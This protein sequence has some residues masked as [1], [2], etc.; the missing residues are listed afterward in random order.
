MNT[1]QS[2]SFFPFIL[3]IAALAIAHALPSKANPAAGL[4]CAA[5]Y[6]LLA[7]WGG[8]RCFMAR[9]APS[10]A[11][12]L[13][14]VAWLAWCFIALTFL[15]VP[16]AGDETITRLFIGFVAFLAAAFWMRI[17]EDESD[18]HSEKLLLLFIIGMAGIFILMA[19]HAIWQRYVGYAK[20]LRLMQ[21]TP[22]AMSTDPIMRDAI[23]WALRMKAPGSTFGDPNT[24]AALLALGVGLLGGWAAWVMQSQT[25][26]TL[27]FAFIIPAAL[28]CFFA[29]ILTQS[30]GGVLTLLLALA[31]TAILVWST[32]GQSEQSHRYQRLAA[33]VA[34]CVMILL[35]AGISFAL[36]SS[37]LG[38]EWRLR[39]LSWSTMQQRVFY[40]T[41]ALRMWREHPLLGHGTGAFSLL[42][43]KYRIPGSGEAA[44]PHNFIAR[45]LAEQGLIGLAFFMLFAIGSVALLLRKKTQSTG[46]QL[47]DRTAGLAI[48]LILF[49]SLMQHAFSTREVYVNFCIFAGVLAGGSRAALHPRLSRSLNVLGLLAL[50]AGAWPSFI[51]PEWIRLYLRRSHDAGDVAADLRA[52]GNTLQSAEWAQR[53]LDEANRA[54]RLR[55]N[56]PWTLEYKAQLLFYTPELRNPAEALALQESAIALNPYSATFHDDRA[57]M[58]FAIGQT[59]DAFREWSAAI[60][61]HPLNEVLYAH[62]AQ[63][64]LS[65]DRPDLA[66]ED[67]YQAWKLTKRSNDRYWQTYSD[68]ARAAGRRAKIDPG[69]QPLAGA[70]Q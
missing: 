27:H 49:N 68:I 13:F 44:D 14:A 31:G 9:I 17:A 53:L 3:L 32:L 20:S 21:E 58:L 33:W 18:E 8:G 41:S 56:D 65:L 29:I 12:I 70:A 40:I 22:G 1:R 62:R 38:R 61:I 23:M 60:G 2:S 5:T 47:L 19:V 67:A 37:S 30:R 42:Y 54:L 57:R 55:H 52:Q 7:I 39:L 36:T 45:I 35:V 50:C 34:L 6:A 11:V 4:A 46:L 16:G 48:V 24:C 66:L 25:R 59:N 28:V 63:A 69:T 64:Y 43:A 51:Q 26:R 10:P 15:H